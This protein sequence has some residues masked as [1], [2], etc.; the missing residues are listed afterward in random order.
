MASRSGKVEAQGPAALLK[1]K[2]R[3][4]H[5]RVVDNLSRCN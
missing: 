5:S 4:Y 3:R 2:S 1:N